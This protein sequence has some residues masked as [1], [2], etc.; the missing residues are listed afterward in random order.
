MSKIGDYVFKQQENEILDCNGNYNEGNY[1]EN[2][3]INQ[4]DSTS[5][6]VSTKGDHVCGKGCNQPSIPVKVCRFTI[7][8]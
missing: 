8:S 6:T 2:E 3:R 4:Q 1:H 5:V 7:G